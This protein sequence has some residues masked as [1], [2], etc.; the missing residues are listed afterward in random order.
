M[1]TNNQKS[2]LV[3]TL[4]FIGFVL[5]IAV[6]L[7]SVVTLIFGSYSVNSFSDEEEI[8][9]EITFCIEGL[10]THIYD[11]EPG[12]SS[13]TT[14][15]FLKVGDPFYLN[16][17]EVGTI[18]TISYEPY[19]CSTGYENGEGE[20]LYAAYPDYLNLLITVTATATEKGDRYL[21]GGVSVAKNQEIV[22]SSRSF[23][24]NSKIRSVRALDL[25]EWVAYKGESN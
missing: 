23:E 13:D 24:M 19:M 2:G 9:L 7:Y 6:I 3:N 11:I 20:L 15:S 5:L 22:F 10:D 4:A 16:G 8:G 14:C 25:A 12:D 18:T 21:V 17:K 1:E